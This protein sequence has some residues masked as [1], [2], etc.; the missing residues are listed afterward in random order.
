MKLRFRYFLL[1]AFTALVGGISPRL[2]GKLFEFIDD[3][4]K[5]WNDQ[6]APFEERIDTERHDFTQ[7]AL[8]VGRGVFQAESG[9]TYIYNHTPDET[10]STHTFPEML[11]RFGLSEDIEFRLRWNHVWQFIDES[12]DQTGSEDLRYSFKF[13]ITREPANSIVP[14][15]ALELRGTAPTGS[16][17]F[18]TDRVEFAL[19]YIY[20]WKLLRDVTLAGSTG[21][22]TNGFAD[23]G[24]LPEDPTSDQ[25]TALSQSVALGFELSEINTMYV[26]WY[27][28]FSQ[29]LADE[30]AITVFN[31][32][33]DHYLTD[34]LVVDFRAGMGLSA[35]A[36]DF[37][38][39][40]GG[41]WR[42]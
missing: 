30:F 4:E 26:E 11:L 42:F 2:H 7:S 27:W 8:T 16:K 29:G 13:Q 33:V 3:F 10:E 22:G 14:T 19:D 21:F 31:M 38:A 34:N 9:Y 24:L 20:E 28:L 15:S 6:R 39:G 5:P 37:F 12:A 25:F 17:E 36:D 1:I 32:G 41:G 40:L 18:S 35:D 23:F